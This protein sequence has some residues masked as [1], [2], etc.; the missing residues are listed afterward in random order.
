[1]ALEIERKF[2]LVNEEWKKL[3]EGKLY[4]Q[5]YLSTHEARAVRVRT[6]GTSAHLTIKGASE[7]AARIEFEYEIP[8]DQANEMLD[9]LCQRPIIEKTRYKIKHGQHLWEVD[10]F[11]GVNEG[12]FLAEVELQSES[13]RVELPEW[14]GAEVTGDAA[15]YNASLIAS[16]FTT[17]SA[18]AQRR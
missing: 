14:V 15:Y 12:L 16:P 13:E 11:H 6:V 8:L 3:A 2:L 17:W 5:G 9:S 4:R 10:E 7:G 18:D 1:M